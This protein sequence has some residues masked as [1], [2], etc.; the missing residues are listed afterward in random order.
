MQEKPVEFTRALA[1]FIV[2]VD[3]S[4]I[5]KQ[6]YEHAKV[7]FMDWIAVTLAGKD[8]PLVVKLIRYADLMGGKQ[9]ATYLG[10]QY[11]Q[12]RESG[13]PDQWIRVSCS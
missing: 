13:H 11:P 5:P 6:A 12:V 2:T 3:A 9:Q 1:R 8:D 10:P 4:D 7:A